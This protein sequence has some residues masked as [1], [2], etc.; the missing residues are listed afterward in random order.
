MLEDRTRCTR[1][2]TSGLERACQ[3]VE[4]ARHHL[5]RKAF[6]VGGFMELTGRGK[7]KRNCSETRN[8]PRPAMLALV[9]GERGLEWKAT[10]P[11]QASAPTHSGKGTAARS[12]G[13]GRPSRGHSETHVIN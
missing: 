9:T 6:V 12:V 4:E 2:T 11:L 13:A 10:V 8:A 7:L 5:F 1:Y 3:D